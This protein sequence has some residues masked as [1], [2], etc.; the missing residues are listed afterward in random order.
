ML[1]SFSIV[2]FLTNY[3][4]TNRKQYMDLKHSSVQKGHK[5]VKIES[6]E[7]TV[8]KFCDL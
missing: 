3:D 2:Q 4:V 1:L 8:S 6:I 5:K 7:T